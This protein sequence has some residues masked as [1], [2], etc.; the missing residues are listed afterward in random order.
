M[1]AAPPSRVR[2]ALRRVLRG[3]GVAALALVTAIAGIALYGAWDERRHRP[4][5][6]AMAA[7][8]GVPLGE[9]AF[10]STSLLH[11]WRQKARAWWVY[12]TLP[13][14]NQMVLFEP[15]DTWA[16]PFRAAPPFAPPPGS[17]LTCEPSG[18]ETVCRAE[19]PGGWTYAVRYD[20]GGAAG[21]LTAR[22]RRD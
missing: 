2:W 6:E 10:S 22:R 17:P 19:A 21:T 18:A 8:V 9:P 16:Y 3:L 11:G 7:L 4:D 14:P 5:A 12:Y 13:I 20:P 1:T 15:G